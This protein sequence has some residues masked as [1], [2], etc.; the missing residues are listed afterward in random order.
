MRSPTKP[1]V[2]R[3]QEG[4]N[5]RHRIVE[6]QKQTKI[7]WTQIHGHWIYEGFFNQSNESLNESL[8]ELECTKSEDGAGLISISE[9]PFSSFSKAWILLVFISLSLYF[10][11][12]LAEMFKNMGTVQ[13][14]T[15]LL[16]TKNVM[17][18]LLFH[19]KKKTTIQD[20]LAT[21]MVS[22]YDRRLCSRHQFFNCQSLKSSSTAVNCCVLQM[23]K[24]C[25]KE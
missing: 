12:P 4:D 2:T 8:Q 21:I 20:I 18:L 16:I 7:K 25:K 11:F 3:Q 19:L 24:I 22:I 5:L 13:Q 17:F 1:A 6:S 10:T 23:H 15:M 9:I 14:D